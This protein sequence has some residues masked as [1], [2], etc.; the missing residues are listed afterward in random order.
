[1]S[2]IFLIQ[3]ALIAFILSRT[4]RTA[5]SPGRVISSVFEKVDLSTVAPVDDSNFL[6][7]F[8]TAVKRYIDHHVS[9]V[10]FKRNSKSVGMIG[11][12]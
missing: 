7:K 1:M 8:E 11:C 5:L 9:V 2:T 12:F 3:A 4:L 6:P 10:R